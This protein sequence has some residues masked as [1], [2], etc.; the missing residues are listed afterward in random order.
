[1]SSTNEQAGGQQ[2]APRKTAQKKTR[3]KRRTP[4][5][6]AAANGTAA[7]KATPLSTIKP[8]PARAVAMTA[9][10]ASSGSPPALMADLIQT[11]PAIGSSFPQAQQTAFLAAATSILG[12]LYPGAAKAA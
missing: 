12:V 11:L 5:Q 10:A 8:T 6:I 7:P 3:A 9:R 1:M 2:P 4:A